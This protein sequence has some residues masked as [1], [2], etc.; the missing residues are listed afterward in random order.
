[1]SA[2]RPALRGARPRETRASRGRFIG[3][4]FANFI[5]IDKVDSDTVVEWQSMVAGVKSVDFVAIFI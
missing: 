3:I 1:M 2:L 5:V 4:L